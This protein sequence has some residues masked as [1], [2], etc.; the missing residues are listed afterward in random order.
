LVP[1]SGQFLNVIPFG[2]PQGDDPTGTYEI[3]PNGRF[4]EWSCKLDQANQSVFLQIAPRD[5]AIG[6]DLRVNG[7]RDLQQVFIGAKESH[8]RELPMVLSLE[9][10]PSEPV[11][12][13]P[14]HREKPGFYLYRHWGKGSPSFR[15]QAGTL[16]E[17]S[18]KQLRSLGYLR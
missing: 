1:R 13:R 2:N 3:D 4:V 12:D 10:S 15:A 5:A 6:F 11:I 8:P 17:Q 16:D 14:F 18:I 7:Q 9:K